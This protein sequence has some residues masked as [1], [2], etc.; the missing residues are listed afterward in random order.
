MD[1]ATIIKTFII[2]AM[3]VGVFTLGLI[4]YETLW[5][6]DDQCLT[7]V[8]RCDI[9]NGCSKFGDSSA[10]EHRTL[11]PITLVRIQVPDPQESV[12]KV[13]G[14]LK[15]A[16]KVHLYDD[17]MVMVGNVYSDLYNRFDDGEEIKTSYIVKESGEYVTT[18]NSYYKVQWA[19]DKIYRSE[20][21]TSE[22]QSH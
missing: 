13:T 21:H 12:M 3:I 1:Q 19:D 17:K 16:K 2:L 11:T 9:I 4:L 15:N 7:R 20:E 22:L 8:I 10:V 5:R 6:N 14:L 18:K